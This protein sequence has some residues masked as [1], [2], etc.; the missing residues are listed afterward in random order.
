MSSP[1]KMAPAAPPLIF[2]DAK[3]WQLSRGKAHGRRS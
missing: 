2:V 3:L 1:V